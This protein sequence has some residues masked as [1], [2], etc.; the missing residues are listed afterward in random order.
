M[1]ASPLV[2]GIGGVFIFAN[3]P[4]GLRDWYICHF[5]FEFA[6]WGSDNYGFD[7]LFTDPDGTQGQTVFSIMKA[8]E[9]LEPGLRGYRLNWR[10]ANL[11]AFLAKLQ[12]AGIT[13]EKREDSEY[14][15]FAWI[16]D[17]EGNKLELYEPPKEP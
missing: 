16:K 13:I 8:K 1:N 2:P 9:P 6:D 14:G 15:K 17:P 4:A 10:V 5:G 11:D 7:F 3:D 12:A